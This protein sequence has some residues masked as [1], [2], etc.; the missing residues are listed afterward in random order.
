MWGICS[1]PLI[2]A[3]LK[4]IA[5]L[6]FI[7][8]FHL[9]LEPLIKRKATKTKTEIDD[10]IVGL[11][12]GPTYLLI[13]SIAVYEI[14][15]GFFSNPALFERILFSLIALFIAWAI[16]KMLDL[17][18]L[19]LV[20]HSKWNKEAKK[21]FRKNAFP[22]IIKLVRVV[23]FLIV[24]LII[25]DEW[26][27]NIGP[28]LASAGIVGLA[29]GFAMKDFIENSLSGLIILIDRPF[30]VGD[31]VELESGI[32]GIVEEISIRTTKIKRYSNDI[33]I[34][35]N[36]QMVN[37][38]L[39]N[40][41]KPDT[42]VRVEIPIGVAYGSDPEKVKRIL[43]RTVRKIDEVLAQPEPWVWFVEMGDFSLNFKV[44]FYVDASNKMKAI[45]KYLSKIYK[46][47][48]R[49]GVEI[50]FPTHTVYLEKTRRKKK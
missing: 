20:E 16:S 27:I 33:V 3:I 25:L 1:D 14:F 32:V 24:I 15:K 39:I 10:R 29:L 13:V 37:A 26:G 18:I 36:S 8:L 45:D 40:Y 17:F 4:L 19:G 43:L 44:Y 5:V 31:K 50:P 34:V 21:E 42:I 30:K 38:R 28:L 7:L 9:I 2:C 49:N 23:I 41:T 22:L 12:T 48:K 35:P 11:I 46:E 6:V 47:L